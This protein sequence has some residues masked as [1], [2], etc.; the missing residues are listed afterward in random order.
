[1]TA[2]P[3]TP[4]LTEEARLLYVL[5]DAVE[6]V[7]PIKDPGLLRRT[8]EIKRRVGS[9]AIEPQA[10]AMFSLMEELDRSGAIEGTWIAGRWQA[11]KKRVSA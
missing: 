2:T 8:D 4:E 11:L 3:T 5:L 7:Q 10:H 9:N 1:M 6:T